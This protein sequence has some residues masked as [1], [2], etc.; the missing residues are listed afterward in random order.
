M[1]KLYK[2]ESGI[3]WASFR[4]R[5]GKRI[6]V[7]TSQ[8]EQALA[9]VAAREL[10]REHLQ[11]GEKP[12]ALSVLDAVAGL[13]ASL[14]RLGRSA[15]TLEFASK[16]AR[17]VVKALGHLDVHDLTLRHVEQYV[18]ARREE[19]SLATVGK[20]VGLLR[21]ALRRARK[22][23]I[24]GRPAYRGDPADVIPE[25]VIG[26]YTPRDRVLTLE[27]YRLVRAELPASRRLQFD[28]YLF[29]GARDSEPGRICVSHLHFGD[30]PRV[31]IPGTKTSAAN[32][33]VPL[34]PELVMALQRRV[35]GR[36]P[37]ERLFEPWKN[38]RR[39]LRAACAKAGVPTVS[40]NDLRRTFA[41]WLA[42]RGVPEVTVAQLLGH[43]SSAM[44]RRVYARIGSS[45]QHEAIARLPAFET[46]DADAAAMPRRGPGTVSLI[47]TGPDGLEGRTE[48]RITAENRG[49]RAPARS[50]RGGTEEPGTEAENP[51]KS[52]VFGVPR[53]GIE[54]ATRGFSIPC[55]T[56]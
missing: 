26:K 56:N 53:A 6:R 40:P 14:G 8:R 32:R 55:S 23:R 43:R 10:E 52:G 18:D 38:V 35:A 27:E 4:D 36:A 45:A 39:D 16:K 7:S 44:V 41:S 13:L 11:A 19:V 3:W 20:E 42:E 31:E 5:H 1:A 28:F 47:V 50:S 37:G 17:Q 48:P 2:R 25:G 46:S 30:A 34:R 51:A 15:G 24:H 9:R 54:P 22:Q 49:E 29:T 21:Q 12:H 33:T